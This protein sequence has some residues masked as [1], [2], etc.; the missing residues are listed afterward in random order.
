MR[1]AA[2]IASSLVLVFALTGPAAAADVMIGVT[3]PLTGFAASYGEDAK[4]GAQLAADQAN[5][6]GGIKGDQIKLVV[7]DDEG[8][9]KSGVSATQKLVSVDKVPVIIGGMMSSVALPASQ[10]ARDNKV[11]YISTM[12]SNPDLT[13]PGGYIYRLAGSDALIGAAEVDFD[14]K[15]L[16]AKTA[17]GLFAQ[18]DYGTM[19][20]KI[21]RAAFE[22][23]GGKWLDTEE[24]KEGTTDFHAAL[25]KFK[26][27]QPDVMFI[28]A[29]HKEAA[30][31]FRQMTELNFK[32]QIMGTSM[33]DDPAIFD[34]AG[35]TANGVYF[36]TSKTETSPEGEKAQ[37]AFRSAFKAKYGKDPGIT[38][39]YFYDGT[40]LAISAIKAVGPSGPAIDKWV[41]AVKDFPG[42]TASI[43][44]TAVGDAVIPT[45]I[46]KIDNSKF[47]DTGFTE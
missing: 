34:L 4:N 46:K 35:D 31:L 7:E 26:A 13:S 9:G 22:K 6:A 5:A 30:Q 3:L 25:A 43:T 20:G 47:V 37:A 19:N 12:S 14:L 21:V 42:A 16:K 44:F 2:S 23:Q 39:S 36:A 24:F 40:N 41:A 18:T 27:A 38:A 32:P 1:S 8:V 45:T 11:V 29:T 15:T 28:V 33:L 10:V 17:V